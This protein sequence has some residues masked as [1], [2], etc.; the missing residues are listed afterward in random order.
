MGKDTQRV[1]LSGKTRGELGFRLEGCS[2]YKLCK[3]WRYG[4]RLDE[5][6]RQDQEEL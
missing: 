6:G 1:N 5:K 3:E 2:C 4:P